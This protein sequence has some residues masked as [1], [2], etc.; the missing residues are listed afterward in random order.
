MQELQNN[1]NTCRDKVWG[2]PAEAELIGFWPPLIRDINK[3]KILAT[4][5]AEN[6]HTQTIKNR[7]EEKL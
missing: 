4:N 3:N 7:R 6:T 5:N 1:R 2:N